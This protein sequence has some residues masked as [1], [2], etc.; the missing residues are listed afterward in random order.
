VYPTTQLLYGVARVS[1]K[2]EGNR[3]INYGNCIAA[4]HPDRITADTLWLGGSID[5]NGL[6][7]TTKLLPC[8]AL[9]SV[10]YEGIRKINFEN[11]N[12]VSRPDRITPGSLWIGGSIDKNGVYLTA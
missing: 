12:A 5:K 8:F 1:I 3:E 2:N 11:F 7:T 6:Y 9:V 10:K 4:S